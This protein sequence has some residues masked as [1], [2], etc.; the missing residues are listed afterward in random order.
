MSRPD[1]DPDAYPDPPI[2]C[3]TG[4]LISTEP[5]SYSTPRRKTPIQDR[6]SWD[7]RKDLLDLW[8]KYAPLPDVGLREG[9]IFNALIAIAD[10]GYMR[11][12][13]EEEL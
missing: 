8:Q 4:G 5:V 10:W 13:E 12:V 1:F 2:G 6:P 9:G 7:D 11:R 3:L